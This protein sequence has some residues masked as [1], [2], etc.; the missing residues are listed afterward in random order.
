MQDHPN[1]KYRPRRRKQVK[2][3]KRLDSG[4]LVHGGVAEH[5]GVPPPPLGVEG[6]GLGLGYHEHGFQLPQPLGHYR[7]GAGAPPLVLLVLLRGLQPPHAGHV[8]AGRRRLGLHVLLAARPGRLPH[9]GC[10]RLPP[11][12]G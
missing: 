7:D 2:R 4:F 6:L 12:G 11:A 1:Y 10:L 5:G 8:P 9:D 3:I